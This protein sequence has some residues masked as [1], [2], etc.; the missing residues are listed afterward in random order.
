MKRIFLFMATNIAIMITLSIVLSLLGFTGYLTA[1]GLDYAGL[2][3]F[4]LVWGMGGAFISL[5]MSRW[6]AKTAMGV[7]LV[8]GRTGH[9]DLDWLYQTV[10]QQTRKVGLPMPEVGVYDSPEVNAF[11][12]GPSKSRS[13]VAVSSGLLRSMQRDE[14]AGV[15]A[16][17][18]SHISNGDMVTMTLI[19]GVVNAF[20]I[21]FSRVIANIIRQLVDERI[22][23]LVF[24]VAT[25][26][27]DII[28]SMLG[29]IVVAW[30]SRAREFRADEGGATI[31]GRGN[32]IAAL[33]RLQQNQALVDTS[34]P[35][36]ATMK[37]SGGKAG[38]MALISTHPPLEVRIAAL[39][40]GK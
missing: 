40:Q 23:H 21:F 28:F 31:A 19:Q 25:I 2:M 13:L 11:A 15:L 9:A 29:M 17:E 26:V 39:Q 18:V 20:S 36:L 34:Q 3:M 33:Q 16:H 7:Q 1:D 30:F 4:S 14:V 32:M 5:A 24:F 10:E 35:Q 37:I 27:F 22:S 12:T 6:M 8:D 38:F